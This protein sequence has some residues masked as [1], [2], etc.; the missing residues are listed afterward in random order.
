MAERAPALATS[1]ANG[2]KSARNG[3]CAQ[4]ERQK[5]LTACSQR[6]SGS[7]QLVLRFAS[8]RAFST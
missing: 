3:P 6:S 8:R 7:T 4:S 5:R 1:A 2:S